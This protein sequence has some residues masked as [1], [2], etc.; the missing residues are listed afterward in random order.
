MHGDA[1]VFVE[2]QVQV[3]CSGC[4]SCVHVVLAAVCITSATAVSPVCAGLR[5]GLRQCCV[6]HMCDACL[7]AHCQTDTRCELFMLT[8]EAFEEILNYYPRFIPTIIYTA[9]QRLP[10]AVR[11][12]TCPIIRYGCACVCHDPLPRCL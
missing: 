2:A 9:Q 5:T 11:S 3:V 8:S 10:E 7:L 4:W 1:V 6:L 12:T